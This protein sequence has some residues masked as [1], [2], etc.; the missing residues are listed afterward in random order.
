MEF[1]TKHK[2]ITELQLSIGTNSI[3]AANDK[4]IEELYGKN[5]ADLSFNSLR[6]PMSAS[7]AGT[8]NENISPTINASIGGNTLKRYED[9]LDDFQNHPQYETFQRK[10]E[11]DTEE[12]SETTYHN[13]MHRKIKNRT[14]DESEESDD[15]IMRST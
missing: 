12:M 15:D 6:E 10:Q 9:F 1:N 7:V 4:D 2:Y 14:K 11:D 3:K 8:I 13:L 5:I